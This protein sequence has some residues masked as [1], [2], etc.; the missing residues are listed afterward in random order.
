MNTDFNSQGK[1]NITFCVSYSFL[2]IA[3]GWSGL[4]WKDNECDNA[5]IVVSKPNKKP[6]PIEVDDWAIWRYLN[7]FK[8]MFTMTPVIVGEWV[9]STWNDMFLSLPDGDA[10]LLRGSSAWLAEFIPGA[11]QGR[12]TKLIIH[13]PYLENHLCTVTVTW[14][15]TNLQSIFN[16]KI[17]CPIKLIVT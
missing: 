14:F 5:S 17:E 15:K 7:L 13:L 12:E 9:G 8:M 4:T 2:S 16:N 11:G 3:M 1:I 6:P 10:K